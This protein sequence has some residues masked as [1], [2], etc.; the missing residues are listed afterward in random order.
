MEQYQKLVKTILDEGSLCKGRNGNTLK[1]FGH[2][3]TF[4]MADGFP[5]PTVK[6]TFWKTAIKEM[7]GFLHGYTNIEQ[8]NRLNV[9]IWDKNANE[10]DWLKNPYR[11]GA[12]DLGPI[13][14]EQ[15][16]NWN[17]IKKIPVDRLDLCAVAEQA[18]YKLIGTCADNGQGYFLY[19]SKIDQVGEALNQIV[20]NP[21]SRRI[22]FHGWNPGV[23]DEVSL[24][25]CHLLYQF[26]VDT[27][28]KR[29]SLNLYVR[30][31]DVFLGTPF[32]IVEGAFLLHL[33]GRITGYTPY[34]FQYTIG[35]AHLYESH[36]EK[37]K[38]LLAR[39]PYPLPTIRFSDRI[40]DATKR[41]TPVHGWVNLWVPDDVF[42]DD[43]KY[44]DAVEAE[45]VA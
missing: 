43:Y 8:F 34:K 7:Y 12:G 35:D 14:G 19:E 28:R 20:Y 18:E 24:P 11:K 3:M 6:Q 21:N 17:S 40:P 38:S 41:D 44:H 32:N 33:F 10:E 2:T 42:L 36:I 45:M 22:I 27:E 23:L 1:I 13:Y 9:K 16:R 5:I 25:A 4:Y 26:G 30:S 39:D 15:W 29:I 37:A 31:N